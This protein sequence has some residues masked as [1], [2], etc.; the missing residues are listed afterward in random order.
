MTFE[1]WFSKEYPEVNN[2]SELSAKVIKMIARA[3]WEKAKEEE[4]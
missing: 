4:S 3:A 1:E 2:A